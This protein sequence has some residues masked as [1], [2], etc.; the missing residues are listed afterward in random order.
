M[1][2]CEDGQNCQRSTD[3]P[4]AKFYLKTHRELFLKYPFS[5][6]KLSFLAKFFGLSFGRKAGILTSLIHKELSLERTRW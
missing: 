2:Q 1:T 3:S 6:L 5:L 4:V